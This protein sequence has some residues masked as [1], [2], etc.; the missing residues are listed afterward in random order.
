MLQL[1]QAN[2]LSQVLHHL[3]ASMMA[4]QRG[5]GQ[6]LQ[7]HAPIQPPPAEEFLPQDADDNEE[8]DQ[9]TKIIIDK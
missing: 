4:F 7:A 2:N 5:R 8:M 1:Q 3:A 9:T 6:E